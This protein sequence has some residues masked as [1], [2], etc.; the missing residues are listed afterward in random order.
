MFRYKKI[1][2]GKKYIK[3]FALDLGEKNLVVLKGSRG[4]VM[5]GYLNMKAAYK[6]KDAAVK[7][8][9]VATIEDALKA[10]V[11][12]LTGEARKLGIYKGQAV[13]EV[14]GIIS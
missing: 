8:T 14:L 10:I 4:Y 5:C 7:I 1:K 2:I 3:A 6:F 13:K 11:H 12:S 9:G